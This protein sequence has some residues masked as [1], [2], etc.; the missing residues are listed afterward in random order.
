[1][2]ELNGQARSIVTHITPDGTVE[3][4]QSTDRD[5]DAVADNVILRT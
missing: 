2:A 3:R 4:L 1:M 5:P